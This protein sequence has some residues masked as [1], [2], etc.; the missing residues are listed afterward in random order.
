M[1][2][3][4]TKHHRQ[5]HSQHKG[6]AKALAP[7]H[8]GLLRLKR[9]KLTCFDFDSNKDVACE[10]GAWDMKL[11]MGG[12]SR[13]TPQFY[14]NS[15]PLKIAGKGGALGDTLITAGRIYK[16]FPMQLWIIKNQPILDPMFVMDSM[17]NGFFSGS[18]TYGALNTPIK[19]AF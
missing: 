2:H 7:K 15:G 6:R 13:A 18:G 9:G 16:N 10:G 11:V 17:N 4:I 12:G 3:R 5:G 1:V 8:S 19:N 14:T